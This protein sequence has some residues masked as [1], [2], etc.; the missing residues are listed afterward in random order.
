MAWIERC[1]NSLL[2]NSC[3]TLIHIIDN[4][5]TDGTVAFIKEN[6]PQVRLTLAGRNLGFGQ[7][8]NVGLRQALAENADHVF[9]LNQDAWVEKDTIGHLVA[10]QKL[11][12]QYGIVS[13]L[14]LNGRGDALDIN[15]A[16][17]LQQS[18]ILPSINS[19]ML[20][21]PEPPPMINTSFVNA[22]A[23]LVSAACLAK[24]GGFDPIFYHYGED[25]NY[26]Q[27]VLFHGF[28]I[29]VCTG[30]RICHDREQRLGQSVPLAGRI[31][32]EKNHFL[33][34][35]CDIRKNGVSF[36][37]LRRALRYSLLTAINV[38]NREKLFY[39]FQMART[40]VGQLPAIRK[41]RR[42]AIGDI[43]FLNKE[44]RLSPVGGLAQ[45]L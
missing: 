37:V 14:H 41:S 21:V 27:R 36:L 3:P 22:A 33:N 39:N 24:T 28:R 17:Y 44:N 4:N 13:P 12:P 16:G 15:F 34:Q 38:L 11:H 6:F 45:D 7:A 10:M 25:E 26:A 1:L 18:D 30:A 40:V 29:G 42:S 9:L 35:A 31:K 23:W 8:N 2:Q 20:G 19:W 32:K 43:P 5:S